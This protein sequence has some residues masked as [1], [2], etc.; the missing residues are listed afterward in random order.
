MSQ[1]TTA[2]S[3]SARSIASRNASASE[4]FS[5]S[6]ARAA[7]LSSRTR[8]VKDSRPPRALDALSQPRRRIGGIGLEQ[9][10]GQVVLR[11]V[12]R[13]DVDGDQVRRLRPLPGLGHH[14]VEVAADRDHDV[15][16]V[17][18]LSGL[19]HVGWHVHEA[20]M[21]GREQ[22]ACRVGEDHRG[23]EALGQGRERLA[24]S[25]LQGAA[26]GPDQRPARALDQLGRASEA[27]L[28]AACGKLA[29]FVR[30]A[31]LVDL[32]AEQV[33]R[34]L[35]VHRARGGGEG[36][37][38]GL[39]HG[40]PELGSIGHLD[41]LLDHRLE[42]RR[43]VGGLV[44]HSPPDPGTA[45]PRGDVGR[46]HEHGLARG[47]GLPDGRQRVGRARPRGGERH[48]QPPGGAG[49][50]VG[51]VGGGLLVAHA[52]QPDRRLSERAPEPQV[53][54]AGEAERDLHAGPL[55]RGDRQSRACQDARP[56]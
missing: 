46:D 41:G 3:G 18:Q 53:V 1:T 6:V 37:A 20:W 17:P 28:V 50:A 5:A 38:R 26:S 51:R 42:H 52:D 39:A 11:G 43:L 45:Q 4:S 14:P 19:G 29:A 8:R 2:S 54:H 23:H 22:P 48:A 27:P 36:D 15:G 12:G 33:G 13:V 21:P 32:L 35:Q 9:D 31:G 40:V 7:R 25:G 44:Q 34:D 55:E 10:V 16:L 56:G 47:P 49:V 30:R 24:G